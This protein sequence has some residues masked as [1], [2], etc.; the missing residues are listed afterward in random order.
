M[1]NTKPLAEQVRF[2][3]SGVGAVPRTLADK[4][5]EIVSVK[6]FG[7]VGD[8]VADDTAALLTAIAAA[9]GK[10]LVVPS[11]VYRVTSLIQYAGKV[12]L[13]G[14]RGA[15]FQLEG[16]GQFL[17]SAPPTSIQSQSAD[18]QAGRNA[19][20][21]VAAHGLQAGDVFALY[22]PTDYSWHSSRNY[23]RDGCMFKVDTVQ[24]ATS[25]KIYGVSP[26]LLTAADFVAYKIVGAGISVSG[27][28]LRPVGSTATVLVWVDGHVGVDI[29][30]IVIEKGAIDTGIEIWRCFD[31][32]LKDCNGELSGG[33]SYPVTISNSQKVTISDCSFYSFRHCI[34]LG[35]RTGD[36]CV[37]TRDVL[38]SHCNLYNA[39]SSGIGAADIHGNCEN[40]HYSD[41][42]FNSGANA[43]GKNVKFSNCVIMGRDPVAYPDGNCIYGSEVVGGVYEF[44]NCRGITY[45][46]GASFGAFLY[47]YVANRNSPVHVRVRDCVLEN[48]ANSTTV[49][50]NN[51]G[52]GSVAGTYPITIEISGF[53]ALSTV[54]LFL[55]LACSDTADVSSLL[56]VSMDNIVCPAGGAYLGASNAVNNSCLQRM[57]RQSGVQLLTATSG[58]T[59]TA[60]E[61]QSFKWSYPRVPNAQVSAGTESSNVYNGNRAV[62]GSVQQIA[63]TTIRPFIE[64]GDAT[65]WTDTREV[66]VMWTVGIE[67]F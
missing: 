34:A 2:T 54:P 25:V 48:R 12:N 7:A 55:V 33:D 44:E 6:D 62:Y 14:H 1:A 42:Y 43:A 63:A 18:L 52:V 64:S 38:I 11:G 57:P 21:F 32:R 29:A 26:S 66:R 40:V 36:A 31:V 50:A 19:V 3:Q 65:A 22:N 4:G 37:P 58:T 8:G 49:R 67:D 23:Y 47:L 35:G 60:G 41:C 13:R 16:A 39:S 30:D 28:T 24:T 15:V 46:D 27:I 10:E 56:R 17:F 5:R 59:F 53:T 45:G 9:N 61:A 51:I 20:S